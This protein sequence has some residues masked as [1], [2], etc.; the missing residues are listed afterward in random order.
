MRL[1]KGAIWEV[2]TRDH[3]AGFF[4]P[5]FLVPKSRMGV[6]VILDRMQDADGPQGVSGHQYRGLVCHHRSKGCLLPDLYLA[7]TLVVPQI[8]VRGA[9]LQVPSPPPWHLPGTPDLH[10][11]YRCGPSSNEAAGP[12]SLELPGRLSGL[13]LVSNSN[14][15]AATLPSWSPMFSHDSLPASLLR[16]LPGRM[17]AVI[18]LA[19]WAS[20]HNNMLELQS[21]VLALQHFLPCVGST[22]LSGRTAR[23]PISTSR[24]GWA[25]LP[26][27][28]WPPSCGSGLNSDSSPSGQ[29]T[30]QVPY[31]RRLTSYSGAARA[32]RNAG[33][34]HR[35]SNNSGAI[36]GGQRLTSLPPGHRH[37]AYCPLF[38]YGG[39]D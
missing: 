30:C 19:Q 38:F 14:S 3:Q 8:Q 7:G 2:D 16:R 20:C 31:T 26:S 37:T 23:L 15:A 39:C 1:V 12:Q 10:Q 34:T 11:V 24:G 28:N 21:A 32:Q 22:S 33:S 18:G 6:S 13:R 5:H 4:F 36:L 9:D 35:L 27:A 25:S 29:C 17:G